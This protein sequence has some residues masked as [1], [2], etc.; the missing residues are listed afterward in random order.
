MV[1][2]STNA[3]PVTDQSPTQ[4]ELGKPPGL[5]QYVESPVFRPKG[6]HV[7]VAQDVAQVATFQAAKMIAAIQD[8]QIKLPD[9]KDV[10]FVFATGK[11]Q[12]M[13]IAEVARIRE[14]WK[15]LAPGERQLLTSLG[16]DFE[17]H[18]NAPFDASRIRAYH[19]DTIFPQRRD[20]LQ[21]YAAHVN[22]F[23]DKM[24][25]PQA[26]RLLWYGDVKDPTPAGD[27]NGVID[28]T[29]NQLDSAAYKSITDSVAQEGLLV[30]QYKSGK[31]SKQHI[32]HPYLRD[33]ELYLQAYADT[34]A[35]A[36]GAHVMMFGV[37]SGYEGQGHVGFVE[38]EHLQ[39][40]GKDFMTLGAFIAN[41][42]HS[43][44]A[45]NIKANEGN[46]TAFTAD[47]SPTVGIA[48]L[49]PNDFMSNPDATIIL[50]IT[51][52]GKAST[53]RAF[54]ESDP[55]P[56]YPSTTLHGI[57][58]NNSGGSKSVVIIGPSCFDQT[59]CGQLPELF[60]QEVTVLSDP[61]EFLVRA[62]RAYHSRNPEEGKDL[63]SI[64]RDDIVRLV[65]ADAEGEE[66]K[67]LAAKL[68]R[69]L[70]D[71]TLANAKQDIVANIRSSVVSSAD[72]PGRLGI[73]PDSSVL[74]I[75]PHLDD[76]PLALGPQLLQQLATI[77]AKQHVITATPGDSAVS[78]DYVL[79]VLG[80]ICEISKADFREVVA[81]ASDKSGQKLIEKTLLENL[82]T[83][84]EARE[85]P[86]ALNDN[87]TNFD[88]WKE[89]SPREKTLRAQLALLSLVRFGGR[90][91][92]DP[93]PF[94]DRNHIRALM[95]ILKIHAEESP[96]WTSP[97]QPQ[98]LRWIKEWIRV[99][100]DQTAFM[101]GA[102]GY[103]DYKP[104]LH[105]S[106]YSGGAEREKTLSDD[107]IE[108]MKREILRTK[109]SVIVLNGE[110]FM[111][112]EAHCLTEMA[113]R[114][115][116]DKLL[117]EKKLHWP[118]KVFLYRGV[119]DRTEVSASPSQLL[120]R[121]DEREL[122]DLDRLFR[123][124]YRSQVPALVPD[125]GCPNTFFSQRVLQNAQATALSL[126][127]ILGDAEYE[128]HLSD[129]LGV[130]AFDTV[131]LSDEAHRRHFASAT[132]RQE[133]ELEKVRGVIERGALSRV[134]AK[135]PSVALGGR[136]AEIN[137]IAADAGVPLTAIFSLQE[138][139]AH[140][141]VSGVASGGRHL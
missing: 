44:L 88:F 100:E 101:A 104:P 112:H 121:M 33:M 107:D 117:N 26:K 51:G 6:Y 3:R 10:N 91:D 55:R 11:S 136:M 68:E 79:K 54:L 12:L 103:D 5:D 7:R 2:S 32:Q 20:A 36:G 35:Q 135:C 27:A 116:L 49:A 130:L 18:K 106:W 77:G 66:R 1:I 108:Q 129:A 124:H 17:S 31:L 4:Q 126:K 29:I 19:L 30:A 115:A 114:I 95:S 141:L 24:G 98:I 118:C 140:G 22:A 21:S 59:L 138:L 70:P 74:H 105:P 96:A 97:R 50:T 99:V 131:D 127:R 16:V 78:T 111:D 110:G 39:A 72:T 47:G 58:T 84:L 134:V 67:N 37:G 48:T 8:W 71:D 75:S 128:Q 89:L 63:G 13:A 53:A 122:N 28:S 14:N 137:R 83:L 85:N 109:P 73:A 93:T 76:V 125:G 92:Q 62:M 133:E 120:I 139:S 41:A 9:D 38:A 123:A 132:R 69:L 65:Y 61:A 56:E 119:W 23:C 94:T 46:H 60:D 42:S 102:V 87:H 43:A 81:T 82:Q 57:G 80:Q 64:S 40:A 25:I 15:S 90:S 34:L 113:T 45:G 52:A 86:V